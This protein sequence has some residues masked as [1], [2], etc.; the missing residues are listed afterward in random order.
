MPAIAGNIR[1]TSLISGSGRRAW[2]PTPEF[3]PGES[4]GQRSLAGYSSWGH[5]ESDT[6]ELSTH[7]CI[8]NQRS[9]S[10]YHSISY[11]DFTFSLCLVGFVGD[12][13]VIP[14]DIGKWHTPYY[15]VKMK[16]RKEQI[17]KDMNPGCHRQTVLCQAFVEREATKTSPFCLSLT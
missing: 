8:V 3:L 9:V 16:E 1:D 10:L 17:N 5:K 4:H 2:Q 7:A 6:T 13:T 15:S 14:R 12:A 11:L